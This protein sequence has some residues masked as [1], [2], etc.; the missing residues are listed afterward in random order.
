MTTRIVM[1]VVFVLMSARPAWAAVGP[2]ARGWTE[3]DRSLAASDKPGSLNRPLELAPTDLNALC[4]GLQPPPA[5]MEAP[6]PEAARRV[7]RVTV[8]TAKL[9]WET[10]Q[11]A[12]MLNRQRPLVALDGWLRLQVLENTARFG[13]KGDDQA[14]LKARLAARDSALELTFLVADAREINPCFAMAGSESYTMAVVPLQWR[15]FGGSAEL[16]SFRSRSY[17]TFS[18]WA[19]PGEAKLRLTASASPGSVDEKALNAAVRRAKGTFKRCANKVMKTAA[20]TFVVGL[21]ATLTS[22]ARLVNVRTEISSAD[23]LGPCFRRALSAV[24]PPRPYRKSQIRVVVEVSRD[25]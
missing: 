11:T 10:T 5:D 3:A 9:R 25:G 4:R 16:A 19:Y 24:R 21:A 20:G 22:D 18:Q 7:F 6:E 8:P 23:G 13:V 14:K 2:E 17:D 1:L 15:L 12:V